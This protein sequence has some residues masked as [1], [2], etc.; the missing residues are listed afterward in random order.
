MV[1]N[2]FDLMLFISMFRFHLIKNNISKITKNCIVEMSK[3]NM[4]CAQA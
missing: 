3:T 1:E 2:N 4:I